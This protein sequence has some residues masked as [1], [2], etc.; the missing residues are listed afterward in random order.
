MLYSQSGSQT[1][2]FESDQGIRPSSTSFVETGQANLIEG[3]L[4]NT[5]NALSDYHYHYEQHPQ[6]AADCDPYNRVSQNH[7]WLLACTPYARPSSRF[8]RQSS[9]EFH[10]GESPSTTSDNQSYMPTSMPVMGDRSSESLTGQQLRTLN[11][12]G[13]H[14]LL[15]QTPSNFWVEDAQSFRGSTSPLSYSPPTCS[16]GPDINMEREDIG[17]HTSSNDEKMA[18]ERLDD[19]PYA[20]LIYS[21]LMEAPGHRMVLK[22]IYRWIEGN[23][24]KANNPEFTGWQNSVRHNLSM[25]KVRP[26]P[27]RLRFLADIS[28]A[29]TKVPFFSPNHKKGYI[30]VLEQSAIGKGI[31]PTTRYRKK[32]ISKRLPTRC[33]HDL[34]RQQSGRRRVQAAGRLVKSK[35]LTHCQQPRPGSYGSYDALDGAFNGL[36]IAP[37][38]SEQALP[39]ADCSY[40]PAQPWPPYAL[41]VHAGS[42]PETLHSIDHK[43]NRTSCQSCSEHSNSFAYQG[44]IRAD[45]PGSASMFPDNGSGYLP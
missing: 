4:E 29:F 43:P 21:A 39:A 15:I 40:S 7:N 22:D 17:E 30:W 41:P 12:T 38:N 2:S 37:S 25:N 35:A 16:E 24:D 3:L 14:D 19:I 11:P 1:G 32:D 8:P 34:Q 27:I 5:D 42:T 10:H 23:T 45:E 44:L 26:L 31:Q 13:D 28:Q 6:L 36:D 9:L 33:I 18:Q 20:Q